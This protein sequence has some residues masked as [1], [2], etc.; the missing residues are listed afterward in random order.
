MTQPLIIY[1]C[2]AVYFIL[3]ITIS[4]LA[5]KRIKG[6]VDFF[7]AGRSLPLWLCTAT[8]TATWFGG[9]TVLGAAGAAYEDGI[10]GV[11][12]DPFGAAVC[13]I[14]AGLF[15]VKTI[16]R[17]KILTVVDFFQLRYGKMSAWLAAIA[18]LILYI[19]WSGSLLVSIGVI[20]E[21]VLGVPPELSIPVG[22]VIVLVYTILGGMWA[23]SLTD[24]IQ[25]II[26]ILGLGLILPFLGTQS[27]G[28]VELWSNIPEEKLYVFPH[29]A[30]VLDWAK[31]LQ[32]WLVI[33]VGG[34]AGQDLLQRSMSARNERIAEYSAYLSGAIYLTIGLIPV[35]IG[36]VGANLLPKIE[37]PEYIVP[38]VA[39]QF[40]PPVAAAI[41]ITAL[42]AA[43]MSSADSALLACAS[44]IGNNI[45]SQ[46]KKTKENVLI[47]SRI[48]I[49][50]C[51]IL[52]L[53]VALYFKNIYQLLLASYSTSL[54][55]LFAPFTAGIWWKKANTSGAIA[56]MSSG[57]ASWILFQ[58]LLPSHPG[59][60]YAMFIS[61]IALVLGSVLTQKTD[62]PLALTDLDGKL[63]T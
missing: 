12:A 54:V 29:N 19:G 48:S 8:L 9:G 35:F 44:I 58:F 28:F 22:T 11:I 32:A 38:Q 17:M 45:L 31:Y 57:L 14:L 61:I 39:L 24:F 2:I 52:A 60:L 42:L 30:N 55:A 59:D 18:Q 27:S 41:F 62:P 36:I 46:F 3:M 1:A 51:A 40:L 13:L 21:N 34:I 53:I 56:A 16:R 63:L 26:I 4:V 50:V 20:I 33:G 6:K 25:V 7:V 23:V 15:Y 5:S 47:F 49:P 10:L 37:N 43:V